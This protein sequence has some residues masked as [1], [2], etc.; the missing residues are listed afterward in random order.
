MKTFHLHIKVSFIAFVHWSYS[1]GAWHVNNYSVYNNLTCLHINHLCLT[2]D[3]YTQQDALR[4]DIAT[5]SNI[6]SI[7]LTG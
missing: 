4:Q 1:F 3:I 6:M 7:L 2:Y 5:F